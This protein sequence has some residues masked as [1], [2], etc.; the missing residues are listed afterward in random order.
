[1]NYQRAITVMN[2]IK[3]EDIGMYVFESVIDSK[4]C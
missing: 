1:M 4:V 2:S 3:A